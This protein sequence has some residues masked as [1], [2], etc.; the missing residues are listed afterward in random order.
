[1][2]NKKYNMQIKCS[3]IYK[4]LETKVFESFERP[5]SGVN[6]QV[7]HKLLSR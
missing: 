4:P 6:D 1:M 5:V 2:K 7:W 3:L